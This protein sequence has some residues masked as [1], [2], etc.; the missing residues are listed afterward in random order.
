MRPPSRPTFARLIPTRAAR[1]TRFLAGAFLALAACATARAATAA[2]FASRTYTDSSGSTPYRILTPRNYNPAA[3]YPLV[4]FL[5]G[6]GER[7]TNNTSQLN[8]NANGALVFVQGPAG[9]S[10]TTYETAYPCFMIA[11]QS[12]GDWSEAVRRTHLRAIIDGLI[13]EFSIDPDRIYVT[14]IS[15]GGAGTWDQ[16][17]QNP[18]RFAAGVPICGWGGG[19]YAAFKHVPLWVFHSANDPTVGVSGSDDAVNAVRNNG[20]DP[21][22]SRYATG[23]HAS[24][25]EAYKNPHLVPWVMSQRRGTTP[26]LNPAL[27]IATAQHGATASLSGWAS[28]TAAPTALTW[29][30]TDLGSGTGSSATPGTVTG[31]TD[32]SASALPLRNGSNTFRIQATGTSFSSLN[33]GVTTFSDTLVISHTAP[34]GDTT[35]PSLALSTPTTSSTYSTAT[36]PL[37]LTGTASDNTAVTSV[38]WSSDRTSLTGTTTGTTSWTTPALALMN[39]ANQLTLTARDAAGNIATTTLLVTYTGASPNLPP[40]VNAGADTSLTLPATLSLTGSAY[41]DGLPAASTLTTLWSVVSGPGTVT[42]ANELSLST[43][44]SFSAPGTYVLRLTAGDSALAASDD[45]TVIVSPVGTARIR[46]DLG[47]PSTTTT[48]NWNNLTAIAA[49]TEVANA[50]DSTGASTGIRI[51]VS[52]AFNA[53]A[54]SGLTGSPLYPDTASRDYFYT[55]AAATGRLEFT[56]LRADRR[57]TLVLYASRTDPGDAVSRVGTFTVGSATTTLDAV[58]N[59]TQTATLADLTADGIGKL[60]LAVRAQNTASGYA[61]L[62]TVELVVTP[63]TPAFS[64]WI[65]TYFPS[66]T[67]DPTITGPEADPDRDGL[68]NNLEYAL[69]TRPDQPSTAWTTGRWTDTATGQSYLTLTF[70]RALGPTGLAVIAQTSTTLSTWSSATSDVIQQGPAILDPDGL[71]ETVTYRCAQPV[72]TSP[73]QF[74]RAQAT[75]P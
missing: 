47:D 57:Y 3:R 35:A 27:R 31:T 28:A 22:Y 55:Q 39:G 6:S 69:A 11:P 25:T 68:S 58:G 41:D 42:F 17:A 71:A 38:T 12:T 2:D 4:M 30:R 59:T 64:S 54:S 56:G 63:A 51:R 60:E 33:G 19:N 15:M 48:G 5:H 23:A 8:N 52:S 20:G 53:V 16:L 34:T 65:A 61:L 40:V 45:L 37:T 10:D 14:G 74:L 13:A 44:A 43:T 18:T 67:S 70:R 1:F 29:V 7:G 62:G 24:W 73:R 72:T 50:I 36:Q 21:I 26:A 66:S 75:T 32:W 9:S 49:N 46:L